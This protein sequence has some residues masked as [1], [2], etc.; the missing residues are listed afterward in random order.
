MKIAI[1]GLAQTGKKTLFTLL[2]GRTVP[3]AR[4]AGEAIE[5]A[6]SPDRRVIEIS[7]DFREGGFFEQG[8]VLLRNR[9]DATFEDITEAADVA[10][11]T[12]FNYF[13]TKEAILDE[14]EA[15][16]SKAFNMMPKADVEVR[17]VPEFSEKTAPGAYYSG[18]SRD[19][20]RPGIFYANLYDIKATPKYG[21]RTLA[22]HEGIPGHHFQIANAMELQ[23]IPEFRKQAGYGAY[24]EGWALYAEQLA[25]E[26]GFYQDPMR[27]FGRLQDEIW[28]SVRLVTDT[29]IHAMRWT[30]EEAIDYFREN[31]PISD[32][33]IVTEVERYFVNPG[34]ALG[35]KVGMMKILARRERAREA[36]GD[37]FDIRAFHDVVIGRGPM[38]LSILERQVEAW[39]ANDNVSG[40]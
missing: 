6:V 32:G 8:D 36:L 4:K 13:S 10:K 2:T 21:M 30:R 31:T 40:P 20:S 14:I 25:R 7:G 1:L 37:E 18:P 27:N 22:V 15:G 16:M 38:P 23:D 26:M 28:R 5:D 11:G 29:G 19:G 12:F 3:A 39:L 17:R 34:Q 24:T 35:Y 9:G 33:D